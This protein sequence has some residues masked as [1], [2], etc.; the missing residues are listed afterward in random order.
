[1]FNLSYAFED[2]FE[3]FKYIIRLKVNIILNF[4]NVKAVSWKDTYFGVVKY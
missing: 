4:D 3:D 1:L 2:R